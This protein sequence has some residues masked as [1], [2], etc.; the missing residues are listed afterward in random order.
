MAVSHEVSKEPSWL[1]R[2][3]TTDF[4]PGANRF[5]YWLK[6]PVG[7]FVAAM[8]ASVLIGLYFAPIGWTLAALL[9]ALIL[10][11]MAWPWVAVRAVACSLRP[12]TNRVQEGELCDWSL[13]VCN[14]LP[15][16]I[17]GLA[18]VG[19]QDHP[20]EEGSVAE[21]VPAVALASVRGLSTC[22]YRF[23]IRPTLRGP[24]PRADA[25]LACSFPFGIW[26]A[27][28]TVAD[29]KAMTV[30]PQ[31]F[32]IAGQNSMAG[33]RR[34]EHGTGDR[35]GHRDD[36]IGL[37]P[38]R[39]GDC[40]KH[41][42]WVAT[43]RSDALIVTERSGPQSPTLRVVVDTAEGSTRDEIADRIRVAAS[44]LADLHQSSCSLR[45]QIGDRRLVPTPGRRGLIQLMDALA[46]VPLDGDQ[47]RP[48]LVQPH[49][50][51]GLSIST[52]NDGNPLVCST[53]PAVHRRAATELQRRVVNR[54]FDL[55]DQLWMFWTEARD[56]HLVA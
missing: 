30:W 43:A 10:V 25:S 14:R 19:F 37:R 47:S 51:T 23:S 52:D 12:S 50:V 32:P 39:R 45:V 22:S 49:G 16:P 18:I 13:T 46:N 31:V 54:Q 29:T 26:T 1:A 4:C 38:Y 41:V 55:A 9:G 36:F 2:A 24:Y 48:R 11:G 27:K 7:W 44:V 56:A 20:T 35:S 6:E 17:W 15:V 53:D 34:A 5:V 42:N 33:R 3:L 40:V 8:F 28:R 21:N